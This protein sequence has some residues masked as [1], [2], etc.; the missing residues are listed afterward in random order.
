LIGGDQS[1]Q[2]NFEK[3]PDYLRRQERNHECLKV[4][5]LV[6]KFG[7]KVAVRKTSMNVYSG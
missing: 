4:R 6:K 5:G 3:I 1:K 7:Q 2:R